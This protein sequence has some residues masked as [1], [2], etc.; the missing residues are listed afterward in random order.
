MSKEADFDF[1]G[2]DVEEAVERVGGGFSAD[3]SN[4]YTKGIT[5]AYLSQSPK[6]A[7]AINLTTKDKEGNERNF[8]IYFT[9]RAGQTFY[10][11]A[12]KKFELPAYALLNSIAMMACNQTA[13][14]MLGKSKKQVIDLMDWESRKEV[15]T[16][17][18]T[19]PQ[20]C[21]KAMKFGIVKVISNKFTKGKATNEPQEKNEIKM[22]FN[23]KTLLTIS[24]IASGATEPKLHAKWLKT[25]E[26]KEDNQF[27]EQEKEEVIETE[28]DNPFGDDDDS[29]TDTATDS[30][31][32]TTNK[33]EPAKS[34]DDDDD[35]MFD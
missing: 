16:E 29:E 21:K 20:I 18:K 8:V 4:V 7:Y 30:A 25:W 12:G 14:Q 10:T 31:A 19:F 13:K 3:E 9:N 33:S 15:P 11:K 32:D 27:V 6:G 5:Q 2:D 26:G 1:G 35:D 28:G 23:T 17:V 24:E 22:I 34:D